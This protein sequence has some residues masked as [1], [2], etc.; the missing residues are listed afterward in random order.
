MRIGAVLIWGSLLV[1]SG[2]LMAQEGSSPCDESAF[3]NFFRVQ[4]ETGSFPLNFMKLSA[5]LRTAPY[6]NTPY[7]ATTYRAT[8]DVIELPEISTNV[9]S[10]TARVSTWYFKALKVVGLKLHDKTFAYLVYANVRGK[11]GRAIG[12]DMNIVF[13]DSS[14]KGVFDTVQIAA[15]GEELPFVPAWVK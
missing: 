7:Q 2:C 12:A 5:P 1:T 9:C 6:R 10:K 14:G 3:T 11:D 4:L 15:S 8:N 13:Y